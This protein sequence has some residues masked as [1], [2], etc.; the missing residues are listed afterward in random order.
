MIE[1]VQADTY[2]FT[3]LDSWLQADHFHGQSK[4]AFWKPNGKE[5]IACWIKDSIGPTMY[6]KLDTEGRLVRMHVQFAPEDQ[7]SRTRVARTIFASWPRVVALVKVPDVEGIA[8][9]SVNPALIEFMSR[10]GF[11]DWKEN[12]YL[13]SFQET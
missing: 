13:Y 6:L 9:E 11:R 8:F 4:L 5:L 10:L 12:D 7:V 2:P 1:F 3:L